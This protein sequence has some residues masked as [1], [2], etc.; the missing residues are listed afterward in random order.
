MNDATT[1]FESIHT[2][3]TI[4]KRKDI[5]EQLIVVEVVYIL[6]N[7]NQYNLQNSITKIS[8]Q[9]RR[10]GATG[11]DVSQKDLQLGNTDNEKSARKFR[12]RAL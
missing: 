11:T 7:I 2:M 1:H 10:S 12:A 6:R 5:L 8:T 3:G 4:T 9:E